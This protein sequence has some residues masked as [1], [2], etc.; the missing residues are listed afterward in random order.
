MYVCMYKTLNL[1]KLKKDTYYEIKIV[2]IK[3]KLFLYFDASEIHS[4][5]KGTSK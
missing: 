3:K 5:K 2:L 1:V 4:W